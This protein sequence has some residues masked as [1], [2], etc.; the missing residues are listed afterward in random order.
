MAIFEL[1]AVITFQI[2]NELQVIRHYKT[3]KNQRCLMMDQSGTGG[4]FAPVK[5]LTQLTK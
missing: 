2:D 4:V 1:S 5:L 3:I